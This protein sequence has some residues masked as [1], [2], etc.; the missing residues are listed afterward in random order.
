MYKNM[1]Q[2]I[3]RAVDKYAQQIAIK[4][5]H[6]QTHLTFEESYNQAI[7]LA[8]KLKD[9]G[10][11]PGDH[12]AIWAPNT[13]QWYVTYLAAAIGG[14]PLV[15][16]NPA[17]EV[18]ELQYAL[19]KAKVKML[20]TM[21]SYGKLNFLKKL[22]QLQK[23]TDVIEQSP[24]T[25][26]IKTQDKMVENFLNYNVLLGKKS[27]AQGNDLI[28][29]EIPQ[30]SPESPFII[31]FTS[32]T[33]GQPKAALVSHFSMVHQGFYMGRALKLDSGNKTLCL[34]VPM[35]H[36]FGLGIV[37]AALY[38]GS[39]LSLPSPTFNAAATLEAIERDRCN[40]VVGTPTMFV[41]ML[42]NQTRMNKSV[43]SLEYA[44]VGGAACT[45]EV[46][47]KTKEVFQLRR[48]IIGY[49][50]SEGTANVFAQDGSETEES[51]LNSVGKIL[52]NC[53]A[54]IIDNEGNTLKFGEVGELCIRGW[55]NMIG[56]YED[57]E[58]TRKTK[59]VNGWIKT[60]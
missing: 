29:S 23:A 7:N 32:G 60:G 39:T 45:P 42:D 34:T 52:G 16:I 54:K 38:C 35:F 18:P 5:W 2:Q 25:V 13:I 27:A 47:L 10:L 57:E 24:L 12:L 14:F 8:E 41:D 28:K 4:S 31:Q 37:S 56:Y 3:E 49:G 26:I 44:F 30:T 48:M 17:L 51:A 59:D 22:Q 46:F 11:K 58:N 33:T 43:E 6:D 15:C 20:I 53:E 9:L 55:F 36:A 19:K 1:G 50:L 40:V 21:D